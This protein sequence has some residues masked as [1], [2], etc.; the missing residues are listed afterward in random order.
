MHDGYLEGGTFA[1]AVPMGDLSTRLS[2][3]LQNPDVPS[4][5][6]KLEYG[7]AIPVAESYDSSRKTQIIYWPA[8]PP[9]EF[10]ICTSIY[11]ISACSFAAL[12]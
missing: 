8:T 12:R 1:P 7:L 5:P 3:F 10:Q 9:P 4:D 2:A 11:V 6:V